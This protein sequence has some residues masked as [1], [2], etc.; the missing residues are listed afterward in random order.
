ME[1]YKVDIV[2]LWVD[3]SDENWL[4]K[5]I[6]YLKKAGKDFDIDSISEYRYANNDE[7]KYS[8]RSVEKF[9]PWINHIYI[10]TDNQ[11]PSWLNTN[12]PKI[13]VIDHTEIF[14]TDDLPVFNSMAIEANLTKIPNLEEHFL[15][16]NDDMFFFRPVEKE[17]FYKNGKAIYRFQHPIKKKKRRKLYGYNINY[18]YELVKQKTGKGLA[19]FNHHNIDGYTKTDY[20]NCINE[21]KNEYEKVSKMRFRDY[22]A[23][24]R[25]A[26]S[27]LAVVNKTGVFKRVHRHKFYHVFLRKLGFKITFDSMYFGI[28]KKNIEQMLNLFKPY[29]FCINDNNKA[30]Q[31]R[32]LEIKNFLE[33]TYPDKSM[34]EK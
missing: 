26:V 17:T 29:M 16:A 18:S 34:F 24:E 20:N 28:H 4:K 21:F 7:L 13:T 1:D 30:S 10:V 2:Y 6:D 31:E 5:K 22:D 32:K 15:F 3:G 23:I 8:L 27:H 11:I 19:F 9:A 33:K 14:N 12:C 25:T